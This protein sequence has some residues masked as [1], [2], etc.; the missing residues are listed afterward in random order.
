MTSTSGPSA[1]VRS[2]AQAS[3]SAVTLA[4]GVPA[5]S[6]AATLLPPRAP[7]SRSQ[8]ISFSVSWSYRSARQ[9]S[10]AVKRSKL[11]NA[12][13]KYSLPSMAMLTTSPLAVAVAR[14]S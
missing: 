12:L 4:V 5:P 10:P 1:P 8:N 2:R 7:W 11:S 14:V 13:G 3:A 9:I 6:A